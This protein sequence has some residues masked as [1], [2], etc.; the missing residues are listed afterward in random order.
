MHHQSGRGENIRQSFDALGR[1]TA[2]HSSDGTVSF[3]Y[4]YDANSQPI[5][6]QNLVNGT[7]TAKC[8]DENGIL[9]QETLANGLTVFN[10][11]DHLGRVTSIL[12]PD[13]TRG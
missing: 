5:L 9:L 10:E 12:H 4:T 3:Q 7:E 11:A 1:L 13:G 8:Y 2:L 6:I